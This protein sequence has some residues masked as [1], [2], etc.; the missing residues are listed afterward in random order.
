[1]AEQPRGHTAT[2]TC[3]LFRQAPWFHCIHQCTNLYNNDFQTIIFLFLA[4]NFRFLHFY[5]TQKIVNHLCNKEHKNVNCQLPPMSNESHT[6]T[7]QM[8][9]ITITHNIL[10][11]IK[12]CRYIGLKSVPQLTSNRQ[13]I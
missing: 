6:I 10:R 8:S 13:I 7:P 11:R 9:Q 1:M 2:W 12:L 4:H 5:S 3:R